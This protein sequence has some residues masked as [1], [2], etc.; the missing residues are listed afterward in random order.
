MKHHFQ[1]LTRKTKTMVYFFLFPPRVLGPGSSAGE[2][3]GE[4]TVE[5]DV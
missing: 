1:S 2:E 4:V 5:E 3:G